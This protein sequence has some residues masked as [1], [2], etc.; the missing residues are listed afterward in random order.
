MIVVKI[1]GGLGNQLFQYAYGLNLAKQNKTNL[2]LDLSWFDKKINLSTK[3][4]FELKFLNISTEYNNSFI[5]KFK[6]LFY[7]H[8]LLK[9]LPIKRKLKIYTDK[10]L[11]NISN[12]DNA[13]LDGYWHSYNYIENIREVLLKEFSLKKDLAYNSDFRSRI[14]AT[15]N[16]V[17]VHIRR[18]DYL[19]NENYAKC[20]IK[21]YERAMQEFSNL[22]KDFFFFI[23]SDD[24]DF[25]K[26]NFKQSNNIFFSESTANIFSITVED[27]INITACSNH[28]ICNST[29]S[30]W[31][32]WLCPNSDKIVI[33]PEKWF[34]NDNEISQC[35]Y[36]DSYLKI[37]ND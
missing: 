27:F 4:D 19:N 33:I 11:S 6:L 1:Y 29:F 31:A 7:N 22:N 10:D 28:I 37:N 2:I 5:I 35:Y 25:V 23:F 9:R 30:W 3:R 16:S 15:K 26:N 17:S 14:L 36:V 20:S 24:L 21:Y 18:S 12:I 32:S 13:Y 34:T 8:W